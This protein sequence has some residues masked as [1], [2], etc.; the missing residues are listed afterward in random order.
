MVQRV[1]SCKLSVQPWAVAYSIAFGVGVTAG[2]S[3]AP[4]AFSQLPWWVLTIYVVSCALG[5]VSG[6]VLV[7]AE[8]AL[9][10]GQRSQIDQLV[11][12]MN[13]MKHSFI[14]PPLN[15]GG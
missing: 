12:D 1:N 11:S 5:L 15:V 8:R 10:R 9:A 3:L 7:I 4:I 2:L 6:V 14:P 13:Q